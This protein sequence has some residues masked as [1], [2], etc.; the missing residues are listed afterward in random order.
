VVLF[1]GDSLTD[2]YTLGTSVAYPALIARQLQKQNSELTVVNAG[3]SGDTT[4]EAL[5]RLPGYLRSYQV[6]HFM[7]A[8]GAND[9]FKEI[10]VARTE[11][12]LRTILKGVSELHPAATLTVAGIV[13]LTEV[14]PAFADSYEEMYRR[15]AADFSASLIPSL[16]EGVT[17][18]AALLMRDG[19]HPNALGQERVAATVWDVMGPL[20]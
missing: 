19:I 6:A 17:G 8:L 20:L 1:F 4:E 15:V 3:R 10:S 9:A 18:N 11:Q 2:G 13:P 16:L 14:S 12:A 7:V 5:A